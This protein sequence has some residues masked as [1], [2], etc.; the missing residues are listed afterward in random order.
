[1]KESRIISVDDDDDDVIFVEKVVP[2]TD[3]A[4]LC[5]IC[6]HNNVNSVLIPCGH[7][8]LCMDCASRQGKALLNRCPICR[9][10]VDSF[11]KTYK[12]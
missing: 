7:L 2:K 10:K 4:D 11:I 5:C 1:M 3:F 12:L 6:L 9:T 8:I